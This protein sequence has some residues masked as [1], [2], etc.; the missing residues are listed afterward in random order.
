M[1]ESRARYRLQFTARAL[2]GFRRT[3]SAINRR[4]GVETSLGTG[5]ISETAKEQVRVL[6]ATMQGLR[7]EV[8]SYLSSSGRLQAACLAGIAR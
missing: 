1:V 7:D 4:Y 6:Q 5:G 2:D 8:N 3:H